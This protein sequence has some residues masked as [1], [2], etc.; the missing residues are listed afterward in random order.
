VINGRAAEDERGDEAK[1]VVADPVDAFA[2]H[3]DAVEIRDYRNLERVALELPAQGLVLIGDNAQGKTN[4]L[5][6][7]YYLHLLRSAR[8]TRDADVVRFG[9][10]AFHLSA[11]V[12]GSR[13]AHRVGAG[14]DRATRT[15]RVRLDGVVVPRL[16]DAVGAIP[17]VFFAPSDV[18]I[19]SGAP[20]ERRRFLDVTLAL[21]TRSYLAALQQYRAALAQRN[22]VLRRLSLTG[23]GGRSDVSEVAAWE[24]ALAFHGAALAQAR[25]EWASAAS[26]RFA[27]LCQGMGEAD[28]AALAYTPALGLEPTEAG[29]LRALEDRRASDMSHGTTRTGP[30]RDRLAITIGRRDLHAFGSAGQH[31]TAAIALRLLEAETYRQRV[32]RAPV[33][34]LD[35]PFAELDHRRADRILALL[36][37]S[38]IGQL[39]LA[40][41]RSGDIP[42]GFDALERAR[43]VAGTVAIGGDGSQ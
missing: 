30:H 18:A 17:S 2:I 3:V 24:P 41:P 31:R 12:H 36:L 5:E 38:E 13:L 26:P 34:L 27:E 10:G 14:Y 16:S 33:F 11:S 19:A 1:G 42:R 21:T 20:A 40:V 43:V 8:G 6:A 39:L 7:I 29:L 4:F 9:V 35:D 15:K 37:A 28:P 22:A 23:G 32:G 25:H